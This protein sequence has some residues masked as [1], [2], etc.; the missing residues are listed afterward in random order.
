MADTF[1]A[2]TSSRPYRPARPHKR[3]L[4]ILE[5]ESG[6]KL[7]ARAVA[8]F[9]GCYS[10]RRSIAWSA[11][12]VA[13]PQRLAS[14]A[15]G[16]LGSGGAAPLTSGLSALGAAALLGGSVMGPVALGDEDDER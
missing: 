3:A 8:A 6:T 16:A 5:E 10:A 7:D 1:Y 15:G 2:M 4:E 11:L 14:W 9:R 13:A 12:A